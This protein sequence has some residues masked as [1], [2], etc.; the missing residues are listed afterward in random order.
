MSL[1]NGK[2][3][4]ELNTRMMDTAD[5]LYDNASNLLIQD[6]PNIKLLE[7]RSQARRMVREDGVKAIFIDYIGL[8]NYEG[9]STMPRHE[10]VSAISR[11]LKQLAR[12]LNVPVICLCQVNREGGKDRP[13]ILADLRDSGSIEQDADLVI[14]L[15]DP[16]RRIG[17]D[18]KIAQYDE[19]DQEA[20]ETM[21]QMKGR[22]LKIIIAKQRNGSTGAFNMLFV[23]DYVCF[24]DIE[25]F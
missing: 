1:R 10:Q 7:I 4:D 12:E 25:K 17:E 11:S 14:L 9:P 5:A 19:D 8:V 16:S 6:T 20:E 18:G 23:S 3:D 13:P 24:R 22:K 2:L 21:P 15:D